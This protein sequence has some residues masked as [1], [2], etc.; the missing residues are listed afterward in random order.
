MRYG[1]IAG[2]SKPISRIVQ[3]T[4]V[5]PVSMS[6]RD[7]CFAL[8][9]GV[10]AQGITAFDTAHQYAHGD[11]E[12]LLGQWMHERG[13]REQVFILSKCA[14][15][16]E[17]R[18]RVTPADITA[19][20]MDSLARLATDYVDL[21]V[22][23]R[24]DPSVPVGPIVEVLNEQQRAGRIGAFGGS[25]W[26]VERLQEANAYA[27]MRGLA[28]FT[29]SSVHLSLAVQVRPPWRDCVTITGSEAQGARDWYARTQT[30]LFAWSSLSGGFCTGRFAR[31][32]LD[33]FTA[34]I[35]RLVI[36]S[37]AS[38]ENFVR[39]ERAQ[40]LAAAKGLTLPQLALA[41]VLNQ[42]F[43]VYA[44]I[45]HQ[46]SAEAAETAVACD[47]TLSVEELD[48]LDLKRA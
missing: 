32:N 43:N 6:N 36:E 35:D 5:A 1:Q 18:R 38:E 4:S 27:A 47:V 25:N 30:P 3:G 48:W 12:R 13:V 16:T 41:Y 2:S 22:L 34:E 28:P 14:H 15:H 31:N 39:L 45:G 23:H 44:L 24:D 11:A 37:Y 19:D 42:P 33:T 46:S 8:F 20:L 40:Q 9:D 17:D 29:A 21:F 26:S 10:F 7:G